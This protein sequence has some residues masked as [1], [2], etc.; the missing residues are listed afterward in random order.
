MPKKKKKKKK[1][2]LNQTFFSYEFIVMK[3]DVFHLGMGTSLGEDKPPVKIDLVSH[4]DG[5]SG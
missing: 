4:P 1:K 2:K 3:I 5:G